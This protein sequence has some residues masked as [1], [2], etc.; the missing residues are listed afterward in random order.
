MELTATDR[1]H[2]R[3]AA[4]G[5]AVFCGLVIMY[6]TR[7]DPV[8]S[9]DSISYLSAATHLRGDHVL[10]EFTGQPLTVFG[11]VFPLLLTIGARSLL[12]ARFVCAT[13]LGVATWLMFVVLSRRIRR[14][15]AVIGA[16]AFGLSQGFVRVGSTVWSETPYICISLAAIAVFAVLDGRELTERRVAVAGLLCGLGFLTRYA[17]IGLIMTGVVTVA[18]MAR[19]LGLRRWVR[20]VAINAASAAVLCVVWVVRDLIE[21]G[22]ALGPRFSG[23][24]TDSWWQLAKLPVGGFGVT[25]LGDRTT[26]DHA[27]HTGTVILVLL[28]IGAIVVLV[29]RPTHPIDVAMIMYAVT[30]VVVPVV[31]R[32]ITASDVDYRVMSPMLVPTIYAAAI[33]FDQRR[34]TRAALALGVVAT[35][36]WGYQGV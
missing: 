14:W 1:D 22:Q 7:H 8:L 21:T 12:W 20:L 29:R 35:V 25:L 4:I 33:V 3:W 23:G 15:A 11:P 26:A 34:V 17:G 36:W 28:A 19:S 5:V 24:V 10:T 13:C 18:F 30:S 31:A 16:A 32:K 2:Q 6:A 27:I 9:P